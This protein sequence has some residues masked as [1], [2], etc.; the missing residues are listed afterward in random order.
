MP[1]YSNPEAWDEAKRISS[2]I[3]LAPNTFTTCVRF[4]RRDVDENNGQLSDVTAYCLR[5]LLKS[6]N[7]RAALYYAVLSYRP[8]Q[9]LN[10]KT[11]PAKA[12]QEIFSIEELACLIGVLFVFRRIKRGCP[13]EH[14]IPFAKTMHTY[15]DIGALVGDAIP[16]IGLGRGL[17]LGTM[18]H[19]SCAMF[20]GVDQKN[21]IKYRRALRIEDRL[22]DIDAEIALW[23]CSHAHIGSFIIQ[24]LGLGVSEASAYAQ[25]ILPTTMYENEMAADMYRAKTLLTWVD[26]FQRTGTAPNIVHRGEFYPTAVALSRLNEFV[27][28]VRKEGSLSYWL[29][30]NWADLTPEAAEMLTVPPYQD[31]QRAPKEVSSDIV[32]DMAQLV[33]EEEGD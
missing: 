19:L 26:V 20:L 6:R 28:R 31:K 8:E 10:Y 30:K 17:L 33:A 27:A 11:L 2:L 12:F 14:F 21:F 15:A 5:A 16:R 29:L 4:L 23:Q 13:S 3:G 24:L 32:Q 9:L 25:A 1:K 18:R 22:F 7:M